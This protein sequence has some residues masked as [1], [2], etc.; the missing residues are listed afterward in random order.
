MAC[1]YFQPKDRFDDKTW[2]KHPRLPLGDPYTGLC[3]VDPM[4]GWA[5]DGAT[6]RDCCN[7][8]YARKKCSRFPD[9]ASADA[10]RFSVTAD[11]NGIVRIFFVQERGHEPVEHG[12][13]D[14]FTGTGEFQG[15]ASNRLLEAQ[16]Q[17]YI[18]S[19]FRRKSEPEETAK[20]PHR[21]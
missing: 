6:L 12:T 21:R 13:L 18:V 15:S 8:G 1:P 17:A 19:Y 2:R 16:A 10:V 3:L 14:Y 7:L 9:Q 11:E 4:R 20:N 5:P